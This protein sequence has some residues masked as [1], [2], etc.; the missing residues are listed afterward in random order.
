MNTQ[1]WEEFM[2]L[3]LIQQQQVSELLR[4]FTLQHGQTASKPTNASNTVENDPTKICQ[5]IKNFTND[6]FNPET[7]SVENFVEYFE[8]KCNIYGDEYKVIQK[9]LF[10][11][12]LSPDVFH[13]IKTAFLE[14]VEKKTYEDLKAKLYSFYHKKRHV[15]KH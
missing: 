6:K 7:T 15:S 5:K 3:Q 4:V 12:C 9:Q 10:I 2:K 1:Q 11:T 8:A 13:K 14:N